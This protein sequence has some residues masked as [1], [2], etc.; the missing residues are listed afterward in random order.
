M[1]VSATTL[2]NVA[3]AAIASVAVAVSSSVTFDVPCV[4]TLSVAVAV[5]ETAPDSP[6]AL[7]VTVWL[8]F[9][10]VMV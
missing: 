7:N 5:S 1:A 6:V 10:T 2:L 4:D 9:A 8:A 3:I